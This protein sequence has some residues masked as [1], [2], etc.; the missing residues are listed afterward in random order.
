MLSAF[1]ASSNES[2]SPDFSPC[3]SAGRER[4]RARSSVCR[5]SCL[6]AADSE[7]SRPATA[8]LAWR[9]AARTSLMVGNR[10]TY[11]RERPLWRCGVLSVA[12]AKYRSVSPG[13]RPRR[14]RSSVWLRM[15]RSGLPAGTVTVSRR[16]E[17]TTPSRL[18]RR[19]STVTPEMP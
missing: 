1:L 5:S 19:L 7:S 14:V 13:S 16:A 3:P 15:A 6:L 9:W 18:T 8:S 12:R 2:D 17:S 10:S 11:S 4:S